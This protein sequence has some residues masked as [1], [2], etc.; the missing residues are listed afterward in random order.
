MIRI[1]TKML[2]P[3]V[4][5]LTLCLLISLW[6]CER[7]APSVVK[8]ESHTRPDVVPHLRDA[9]DVGRF[10][11]GL[12]GT[13]GSP[14]ADLEVTDAWKEHRRQL[15]EAWHKTEGSLISGLQQF[16]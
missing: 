6:A 2:Y 4:R 12:P 11:A 15:D 1:L 9:D 13:P 16:Q 5:G 14:F 8:A 3:A 7:P 10:I